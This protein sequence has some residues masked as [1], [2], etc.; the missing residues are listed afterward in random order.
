[1]A[2]YGE[3]WGALSGTEIWNSARTAAYLKNG[4]APSGVE[5][6]N[7]LACFGIGVAVEDNDFTGYTVPEQDLAPWY[8][9]DAPESADFA[10]LL[11]SEI[12]G[13]QDSPYSR[14]VVSTINGGGAFGRL[15]T[16]PRQVAVR[17]LLMGR[18]C[19]SIAYGMRWLVSALAHSEPDCSCAAG[20]FC[21]LTCCPDIQ[22]DD[23]G[24]CGIGDER[25]PRAREFDRYSEFFRTACG[26]G[27][28]SG[29]TVTDRIGSSCGCGGCTALEVEFVIAMGPYMFGDPVRCLDQ[30]SFADLEAICAIEPVVPECELTVSAEGECPECGADII[31]VRGTTAQCD[32]CGNCPDDADFPCYDDPFCPQP[33][34]P[35]Q[36]PIPTSVC[37]PC[38]PPFVKRL[39]CQVDRTSIKDWFDAVVN[40]EVYSGARPIRNLRI[41]AYPNPLGLDVDQFADCDACAG[42]A[43]RYIPCESVM[44]VDGA[45]RT[46]VIT[47]P[48]STATDA[49][50]NLIAIDGTPF[51]YPVLSCTSWLVVVEADA[52]GIADD[53]WVTIDIQPREA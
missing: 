17:G 47:C 29:P 52:D 53:A 19:C 35:P 36:P 37:A 26:A 45:C 28:V 15:T 14:S 22:G 38:A 8:D 44:T 32:D 5:V 25:E 3:G 11:I 20:T 10:G 27:L 41:L 33:S 4:L 16:S 23:F 40:V 43:I 39:S 34:P 9:P 42:F 24:E 18:T 12:T 30:G 31:W 51:N 6:K 49:D 21:F 48:E 50:G 7:C 46:A 13:L 1:M 2:G